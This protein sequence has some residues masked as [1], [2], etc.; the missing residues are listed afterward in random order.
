MFCYK[1]LKGEESQCYRCQVGGE[2]AEQLYNLKTPLLVRA[3]GNLRV[4]VGVLTCRSS[5]MYRGAWL[6]MA[7]GE[8]KYEINTHIFND[9]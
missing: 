9:P 6:W 8:Q 7:K 4:Q 1:V 5:E 2:W 3:E